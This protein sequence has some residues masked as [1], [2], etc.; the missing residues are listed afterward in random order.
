MKTIR[1]VQKGDYEL[2]TVLGELT[3]SQVAMTNVRAQEKDAFTKIQK[4]PDDGIESVRIVSVVL[5]DYY[6]GDDKA[7]EIIGWLE[8]SDSTTVTEIIATEKNS[9]VIQRQTPKVQ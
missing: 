1:E 4:D 8:G 7:T 5:R 3:A 6:G 2:Q 9:V